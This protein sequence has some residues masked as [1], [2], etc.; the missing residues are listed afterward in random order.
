MNREPPGAEQSS[1]ETRLP[2]RHGGS[3]PSSCANEH[4]VRDAFSLAQ[5]EA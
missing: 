5:K 2:K 4:P 3:N 1:L